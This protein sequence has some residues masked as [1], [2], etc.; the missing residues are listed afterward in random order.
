MRRALY[1]KL[2]RDIWRWRGQIVAIVAVIGCGIGAFVAFSSVSASLRA[3]LNAYY[4]HFGFADVF[5]QLTR[6]PNLTRRTIERIP[7]VA[8]LRTRVVRDVTLDIPGRSEPAVGRVISVPDESPPK[9]NGLF[10]RSGRYLRPGVPGEVIV[11]QAFADGNHLSVGSKLGAVLNG[12]WQQLTVVGVALSPEY[13]YEVPPT[14]QPYP[15]PAHFGVLWMADKQVS[16]AFAMFGAFN[17]VSLR[18]SHEA[19]VP[20]VIAALD[21]IL[22]RYG[23]IGAYD[24]RLQPS[25]K[26]LSNALV[27]LDSSGVFIAGLFL[28]VAAFLLNLLLVRLVGTQR[29]QIAILKAFGYGRAAIAFHYLGFVA[30][31]VLLGAAAGAAIGMWWGHMFTDLYSRLFFHLPELRFISSPLVFAEALGFCAVASAAG[32][33]IAVRNAVRLTPAE[34]M[35]PQS[36]EVYRRTLLERATAALPLEVRIVTRNIDHKPLVTTLSIAG[37][38]LAIALLVFARYLPEGTQRIYDLLFN[39]GERQDATVVFAH[40]L[41]PGAALDLA[42]LPGVMRVEPFRSVPVRIAY[43]NVSRRLVILGLAPNG[44]LRRI[45]DFDGA[46]VVVPPQGLLLS[47]RLAGVLHAPTGAFIDVDVLGGQRQHLRLQVAGTVDEFAATSIYSDL[48]ALDRILDEGGRASGAFIALDPAQQEQFNA[49]IKR[50]PLVAGV[51]YRDASMK[52]FNDVLLQELSLDESMIFLFACVIAFGVAYNIARIALSERAI[53]LSSLRILGFTRGETWRLLVGEQLFVTLA[54]A[55]PGL[56]AGAIFTRWLAV[57]HSTEEY[58]LPWV[59]TTSSIAF[60]M[61]FVL[62]VTAISSLIVR[63]QI[64]RLDIVS[65][66]KTGG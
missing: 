60:A 3:S 39:Y 9:V 29:D 17:D 48:N 43:G 49:K 22:D 2:L 42:S 18:L 41:Q 59:F 13:V 40:D 65:V 64:A 11:S 46:A 8:A 57:I 12:R 63:R 10:M 32:A 56:I 52:N 53:E 34:A 26:L 38:S 47:H 5:D 25:S 20:D 33:V 27:S 50:V 7:G 6:A 23:G 54:A 58:T 30:A 14:G 21:R 19:S 51:A 35:R 44:Q 16:S 61:L 15:D 66:L 55:V 45:V 28:S 24:R 62:G 37:V 31:I 4:D 36:P 1:R